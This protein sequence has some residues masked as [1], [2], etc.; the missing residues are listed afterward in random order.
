MKDQSA[1]T[2]AYTRSAPWAVCSGANFC[3]PTEIAASRVAGG[4]RARFARGPALAGARVYAAPLVPV[5]AFV[6]ASPPGCVP[7][8]ESPMLVV[9]GAADLDALVAHFAAPPAGGAGGDEGGADVAQVREKLSWFLGGVR[10]GKKGGGAAGGGDLIAAHSLHFNHS[11]EGCN[12]RPAI[13]D[14]S[15][16]IRAVRDVASGDELFFDYTAF[17]ISEETRRWLNGHGLRD[18]KSMVQDW[19]RVAA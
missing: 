4:G 8:A 1:A 7:A 11:V 19:Q 9:A 18:T 12:L 2:P 5:A 6:A 16:V 15:F 13:E 14:G 17:E 10:S 3:I